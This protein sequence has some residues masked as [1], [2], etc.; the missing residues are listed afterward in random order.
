MGV[1]DDVFEPNGCEAD[2]IDGGTK[3]RLSFSRDNG[4]SREVVLSRAWL[5]QLVA[6]LIGKIESGP[7]ARIDQG[8]LRP[9]QTFLVQ[10]LRV[11]KISDGSQLLTVSVALP[12]QDRTV[13]IPL[14][15]TP[16]DA[17]ALILMLRSPT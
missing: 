7:L 8:S 12:D 17:E 10:G 9:G 5:P 13:T 14:E 3:V 15:L 4:T 2:L 6:L 1:E 11:R 16:E